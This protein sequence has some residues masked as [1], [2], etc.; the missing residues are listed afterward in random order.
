MIAS[1]GTVTSPKEMSGGGKQQS[2]SANKTPTT[3]KK[4]SMMV[5][6]STTPTTPVA[7]NTKAS[8]GSTT[9]TGTGTTVGS[10]RAPNTDDPLLLSIASNQGTLVQQ[11]ITMTCYTPTK[12]VGA[13]IGRRGATIAQIQKQ[14]QH[15]GTS[16]GAVRL[17]IVGHQL[18]QQQQQQQQQ[19]LLQGG[20]DMN[21]AASPGN[22][23]QLQHLQ[24]PAAPQSPNPS[25]GEQSPMP[26]A[27]QQ[28]LMT[29]LQQQYSAA[30]SVP[31]TY[32]ELDLSSPLWTPIVIRADPCAALTA[33]KLLRDKVGQM[34]DV[35]MDIPLGRAKH[36]A[37]VGRRGYVLANLSADTNVRIMVPRRELRHDIIQLE[38]QLDKVKQC[39]ERVL[40]IASD[41]AGNSNNN[42]NATNSN[43]KNKGG[44]NT[45]STEKNS[46]NSTSMVINIPVLPSQT[47][48]RT[49]GRKSDTIIKKRKTDDNCWD[50][51]VTGSSAE[52]VQSAVAVLK[53]WSEDNA[54]KDANKNSKA[55]GSDTSKN[56]STSSPG[57]NNSTP[58]N[59][60]RG[61]GRHPNKARP[62]K[63]R[64][65]NNSNN[66]G[67]KS[68]E[69]PAA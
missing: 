30:A 36:A 12:S 25:K 66:N 43:K 33:A 1:G 4:P 27:Q 52:N 16:N 67:S 58:N 10:H 48:L 29:P 26:H 11:L 21:P 41:A 63:N 28:M 22:D 65:S 51:T 7:P 40:A 37:V 39:L 18:L 15:V 38:G 6:A 56:N 35:V 57:G 47:K 59:K 49:I 64:N 23:L 13:V 31:Y 50:L 34:D 46:D 5:D 62:K 19:Q 17:S 3:G 54:N 2:P 69:S 42:S 45:N 68:T 32:T 14:A 53:K 20:G 55:E 61:R 8:S 60:S 24:I 44:K 9:T